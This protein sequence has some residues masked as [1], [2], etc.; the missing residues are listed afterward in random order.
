[1]IV[2]AS[3]GGS[4]V[5]VHLSNAFGA[6][7]LVIGAALVALR[8][9]DSA[10]VAGSDRALTFTG[11]RSVSV[12][13][14]AEMLSD[15]VDLVVPKL[16]DLAVSVHVP[17]ETGPASAQT[18]VPILPAYPTGPSPQHV[19][20]ADFNGDGIADLSVSNY[21]DDT[22]AGGNIAMFFGKGDGRFTAGP[23]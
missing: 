5:R 10:I 1:M 16:A 22:G 8:D 7:P 15:P 12:P 17:G 9:K 11:K 14:G 21:G 2:R 23:T 3:I 6:T 13:P 20:A 4:R 18:L 19:I